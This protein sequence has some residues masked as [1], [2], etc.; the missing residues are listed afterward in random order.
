MLAFFDPE[1]FKHEPKF[2][3]FS[4]VPKPNSEVA[5]R[6]KVLRNALLQHGHELKIPK[7]HGIIP[8]EAVHHQDYLHFLKNIYRRW[9]GIPVASAEVIPNIHPNRTAGNIPES[10]VGQAGWYMADTACPISNETWNSALAS[11]NTAV[12]AAQAVLDG[13]NSAY[14]LLPSAR[15]SCFCGFGWRILFFKQ[16]SHY[17]TTFKIELSESCNY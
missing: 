10:A 8:V 1:Q 15:S 7:P 6:A 12:G 3:L 11:A 16:L 4:G 2:S 5:E 13:Q 9:Q 14:A 17:R